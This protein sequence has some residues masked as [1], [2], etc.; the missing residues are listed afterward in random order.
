MGQLLAHLMG[1]HNA[2]QIFIDFDSMA[3]FFNVFVLLIFVYLLLWLIPT[4]FSFRRCT[5]TTRARALELHSRRA[6]D[7]P[8]DFK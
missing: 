2:E 5:L 6:T 3:C 7:G 4:F 1:Q 8:T